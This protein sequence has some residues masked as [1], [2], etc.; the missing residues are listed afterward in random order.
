M[1]IGSWRDANK[2][3]FISLI[4]IELLFLNEHGG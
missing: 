3:V 2:M 1:R 4:A